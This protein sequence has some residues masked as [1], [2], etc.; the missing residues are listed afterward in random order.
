MEIVFEEKIGNPKKIYEIAED[1]FEFG[2]PL[3]LKQFEESQ[4]KFLLALEDGQVIGFLSF[5]FFLDQGDITN[6]AVVKKFQQ[7]G[8]GRL[9][10]LYFLEKMR[11][12]CAGEVFLEVRESNVPAQK[13]YEQCGF[14]K[15]S[16]RKSYY[17]KPIENAN[18]FCLEVGKR[19]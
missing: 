18:V 15:I 3:T 10:M 9:L 11:E 17:K 19:R 5:T 1:S 8:V 4:D 6:L 14:K 13:F 7:K 2:S 12:C 16:T